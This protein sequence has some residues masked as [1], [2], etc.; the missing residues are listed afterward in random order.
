[1]LNKNP[2]NRNLFS[3]QIGM[4]MGAAIVNGQRDREFDEQ[5]NYNIPGQ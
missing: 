1:M 3:K 5:Y 4:G 2:V